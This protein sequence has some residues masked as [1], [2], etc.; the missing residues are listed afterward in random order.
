MKGQNLFQREIITKE[1]KIPWWNLK[2]FFFRTTE[3]ISTTLG[4]KHPRVKGIQFLTNET[5]SI[6]KYEIKLFLLNGRLV[7][8][9]LCKIVF[10]D[11]NC[12]SGERCCPWGSCYLINLY[13]KTDLPKNV[14]FI[15][16]LIN[17]A[18]LPIDLLFWY[19][20]VNQKGIG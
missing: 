6:F 14:Y 17:W 15:K 10:I 3:A 1:R 13:N 20:K 12:F 7:L 18:T 9:Q 5:H 4:T 16:L 8:P 11:W 19:S 2:I